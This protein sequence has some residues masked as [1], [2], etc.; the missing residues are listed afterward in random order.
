MNSIYVKKQGD[1]NFKVKLQRKHIS[2]DKAD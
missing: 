1:R 2:G